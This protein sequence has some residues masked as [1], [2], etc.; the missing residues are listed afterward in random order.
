VA[1]MAMLALS[2]GII[3]SA[4]TIR[5][6]DLNLLVGF[7]V[8][9]MMYASSVIFP[10]SLFEKA[11]WSRVILG[12]NPMTPVINATRAMLF[13]GP[14]DLHGLAYSA[15]FSIVVLVL[16]VMFFQRSERSFADVV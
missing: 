9:L 6:R 16:G 15:V 8:Q 4:M 2:V 10:P 13:G 11:A 3:I 1:L 7:G 5:F 12:L 14:L